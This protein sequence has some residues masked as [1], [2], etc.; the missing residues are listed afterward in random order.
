MIQLLLLLFTQKHWKHC[1]L[2]SDSTAWC[3][4]VL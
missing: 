4:R 2:G 1:L 3:G